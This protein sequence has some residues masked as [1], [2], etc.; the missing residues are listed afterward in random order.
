VPIPPSLAGSPPSP[1]TGQVNNI[2]PNATDFQVSGGK[3]AFIFA[4]EDGTISAWRNGLPGAVKLVDNSAAGAVYKGLA[5]GSNGSAFFLYAANFNSGKIDVF[6]HN[7]ASVALSGNFADPNPPPVPAGTPAGQSYAPFNVQVLN[8]NLYV[9]YALQDSAKHDD[10][11]G[12]GNGFVDEFDLNGNLLQRVATNGPLNSPWGLDI[13]PAG[14]GAFAND[15]LIGNFGDGV[16]DV[17]NA[18]TNLFVGQLDD[19]SGNPIMIDGLWALS[20]GTGGN[21]FDPNQV[22]F[23]AGIN[24]ESDGLFGSLAIVPE[25][26]TLS[27]LGAGLVVLGVTGRRK[28]RRARAPETRP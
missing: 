14:F 9:T 17:Y 28:S 21:G 5:I 20:N 13:A 16:I 2:S 7:F 11:A 3:S 12:S 27:L 10:L 23:N 15:L 25:P 26:G 6:D 19:A 18:L 8:G 24:E 1:P 4:T 22:Y